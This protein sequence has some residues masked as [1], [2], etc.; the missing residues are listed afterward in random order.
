MSEHGPFPHAIVANPTD[1]TVWLVYADWLEQRGDPRA[2]A[3]K[4]SG[5]LACLLVGC[6]VLFWLSCLS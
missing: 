5:V 2:A 6:G 1:K 4:A 3:C